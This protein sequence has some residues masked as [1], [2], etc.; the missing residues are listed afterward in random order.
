MKQHFVKAQELN[1]ILFDIPEFL[2]TVSEE[3]ETL[4]D[5]IMLIVDN[6]YAP[7]MTNKC[8]SYI[9]ILDLHYINASLK[10][11]VSDLNQIKIIGVQHYLKTKLDNVLLYAKEN[12]LYEI[13]HN[14]NMFNNVVEKLEKMNI[15]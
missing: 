13:I 4:F 10:D 11:S 8:L 5:Y 12:E 1:N 6:V 7:M 2:L 3:N 15:Y 9:D 14:L